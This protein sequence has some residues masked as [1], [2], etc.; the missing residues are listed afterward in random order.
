MPLAWPMRATPAAEPIERIDPPTP[1][2]RVI[3]SHW[4]SVICGSILST[5]NIS[6]MLSTMADKAP[7]IMLAVVGPK[8]A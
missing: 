8:P 5:A 3:S 7:M 4:P 1:Q 6:G 2:V